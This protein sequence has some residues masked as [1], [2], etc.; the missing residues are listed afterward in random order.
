[1]I[2]YGP[3]ATRDRLVGALH[4]GEPESGQGLLDTA[5][6]MVIDAEPLTKRLRKLKQSPDE[7]LKAGAMTD[8]EFEQLQ[9][10]NAAVQRVVAV[11]DF[12]PEEIAAMFPDAPRKPDTI[13]P[14]EAA[15]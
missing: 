6:R 10:V 4:P 2:L 7:A 12:S 14:R 9:R 5:Y 1:M 15:E 11:D 3:S 8:G 13:S